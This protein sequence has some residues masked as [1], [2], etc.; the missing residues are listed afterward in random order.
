MKCYL[1]NSKNCHLRLVKKQNQIFI[2]Y[3][4]RYKN[5]QNVMEKSIIP[6]LKSLGLECKVAKDEIRPK[7]FFVRFVN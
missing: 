3:N 5:V 2:A 4:Y 6:A 7:D 1:T